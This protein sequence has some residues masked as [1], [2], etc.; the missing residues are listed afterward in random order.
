VIGLGTISAGSVIGPGQ[1]LMDVVPEKPDLIIEARLQPQVIDRVKPGQLADIRFSAFA[2]SPLLL[3]EGRIKTISTDLLTD[4][5]LRQSYYLAR[6]S[7][8]AEGLKTLSQ[9]KLQ[10]GLPAEVL[11]KTGSRSM[12][13]YI[14]Y[15]LVR[16]LHKSLREE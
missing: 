5:E 4:A 9:R 14:A 15:P 10:A 7:I 1:K 16:R 13:S 6:V 11:I 12:L 3:V 8:T 2:H